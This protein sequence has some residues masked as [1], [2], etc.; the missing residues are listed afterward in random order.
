MSTLLADLLPDAESAGAVVGVNPWRCA[1]RLR[2]AAAWASEQREVAGVP[3]GYLG[4]GVHAATALA[5]AV[6]P[7]VPVEAVVVGGGRPDLLGEHLAA[8][9][10]PTLLLTGRRDEESLR[11]HRAAM[12]QLAGYS[13]S[14]TLR[15]S[16]PQFEEPGALHEFGRLAASWFVHYLAMKRSIDQVL[17]ARHGRSART[18]SSAAE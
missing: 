11:A 18:A 3:L 4:L 14:I 2:I 5:G 10:V 8:V 1:G 7:S 12:A 15:G 6:G 9:Q 13:Q 17:L 16:G